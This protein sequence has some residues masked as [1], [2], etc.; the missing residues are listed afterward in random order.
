MITERKLIAGTR[1]EI[2]EYL[3]FVG[4]DGKTKNP[5]QSISDQL[6]K[7]PVDGM[8][9]IAYLKGNSL[10]DDQISYSIEMI[11]VQIRDDIFNEKIK[12]IKI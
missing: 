10:T 5:S 9:Y 12:K 7:I 3:S 4:N 2:L 11:A 1:K 6:C 8:G